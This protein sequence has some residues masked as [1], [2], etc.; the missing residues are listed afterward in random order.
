[1]ELFLAR[2][3]AFAVATKC[4]AGNRFDLF[5]SFLDDRS[6]RRVQAITFKEE[7]KTSGAID[8][9]KDATKALL[10]ILLDNQGWVVLILMLFSVAVMGTGCFSIGINLN[11]EDN[12]VRDD[13]DEEEKEVV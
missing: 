11:L 10:E 12:V 6:F 3:Q 13:S 1:M 8:L 9:N 7:H 4:E 2:F 5:K